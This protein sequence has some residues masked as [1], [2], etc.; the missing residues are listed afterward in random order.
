MNGLTKFNGVETQTSIKFLNDYS[1]YKCHAHVKKYFNTLMQVLT[2]EVQ[3]K[4]Y[5]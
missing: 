3:F 1:D 5:I 2:I 4:S